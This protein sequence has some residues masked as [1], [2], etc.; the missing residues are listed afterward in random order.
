[1]AMPDTKVLINANVFD[2]CGAGVLQDRYVL[3]RDGEVAE[4]GP[5]GSAP[6]PE[7]AV[8]ID[9]QGSY[10]M[11]GLFNMHTHFSLTLPGKLAHAVQAMSPHELAL[12]VAA[13]A[14]QTLQCGVTTVRCVGESDHVE[15]AVRSAI[16]EGRAEGP[17]ILSAGR[18]LVCTG[19]HGHEAPSTLECDGPD[20]FVRGTRAQIKAGADLIK[21]MISG[22]IAGINETMDTVPLTP[23]ELAAVI[24]T[25]HAW[26]RKVTA[27]AGPARIIEQAVEQGLDCVEH[28][29]QLT[30]AVAQQMH[31]RGVALV[32]TLSVTR[33]GDF[34]D[35]LDVPAW[36]Q[37]R[38]LRA[39][40]VH[41]ESYRLALAAGVAVMLGSDIPPFWQTEGT[42]ATVRELEHMEAFGLSAHDALLAATRVPAAWLGIDEEVGSVEPGKRADLIAMRE[43]PTAGVSA[44][45]TLHWV[46]KDGTVYR[47]DA[48]VR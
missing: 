20:G 16:A 28:G 45:R 30:P 4:I 19:G 18:G 27:H 17:R 43:D 12:H 10:V 25:A 24:F 21:V 33:C 32:P 8:I 46:M 7:D 38:S 2:G 22:G 5:S 11:A 9:L 29:Y 39:A 1:M 26:G 15:F 37:E 44:L 41:E 47:D 35:S 48:W 34:F 13:G 6:E 3:V 31:D 36:M 14:R 40:P 42:S 23:E